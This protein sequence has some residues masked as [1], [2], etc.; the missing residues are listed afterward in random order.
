VGIES[1]LPTFVEGRIYPA[2]KREDPEMVV[3]RIARMM[4]RGVLI[5]FEDPALS[6]DDR[7]MLF[8]DRFGEEVERFPK[9]VNLLL[10]PPQPITT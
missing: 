6:L 10:N 5:G 7:T 8:I 1:G 3:F 4:Q 2:Q 9:V